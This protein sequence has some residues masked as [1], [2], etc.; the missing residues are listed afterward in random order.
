M[1]S[2]AGNSLNRRLCKPVYQMEKGVVRTQVYETDGYSAKRDGSGLF[3]Q[4]DG[5]QTPAG[6]ILCVMKFVDTPRGLGKD[7]SIRRLI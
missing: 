5:N 1:V 2:P 3:V 6:S 4:S 7:R